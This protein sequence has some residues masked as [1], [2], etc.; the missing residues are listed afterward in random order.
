MIPVPLLEPD[1]DVP[2]ELG[3]ALRGVYGRAG[4]DWRIDYRKPVPQPALRSAMAR[5][6][7]E[8]LPEVG[9]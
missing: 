9:R 1:P 5:W 8:T 6:L 4:Y 7:R 2:L 3:E